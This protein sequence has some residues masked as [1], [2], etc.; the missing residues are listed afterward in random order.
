MIRPVNDSALAL[1]RFWFWHLLY[2]LGYL[3]LKYT[4]L[5]LLIPLQQ[6][7][8]FPYLATYTLITVINLSL[9]GW[10]GTRE[11]ARPCTPA[12]QLQR[13]AVWLM[14]LLFLL[15]PLRQYLLTHYA[16]KSG[17]DMM[18][19]WSHYLVVGIPLVLLPL[20]GW[21]AVFLLM[22]LNFFTL[23]QLENRQQL[24]KQ[25]RQARLKVLRYQ[26]NPHFMFNTLNALNSLIVSRKGLAAEDLI[27]QLSAFL[28]H[29]LKNQDD[30]WVPLR[31]ELQ[32]LEAYLAI[33]Q[34]R[35]G[36][37]LV[38]DWQ[39]SATKPMQLPPLLFQ[40][41]AEQAIL[42]TVAEQSGPI[43]L[44]IELTEPCEP[45][46]HTGML[47]FIIRSD[48]AGTETQLWS[49]SQV[50]ASLQQLQ[51]RL[52]LLFGPRASLTLLN[53]AFG[54]YARLNLPLEVLYAAHPAR[55]RGR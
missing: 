15:I 52:E 25:A 43:H 45:G 23:Q 27:Q 13:L 17:P 18:T 33:Q 46:E 6:E 12:Q 8:A 49:A 16:M 11:L 42:W 3:L 44:H 47:Q 32:A 26:L 34:V 54:F 4:H 31:E 5:S 38:L 10:L 24:L 28:R 30:Q 37:R 40:P 9:T 20:C 51:E 55:D 53:P 36:E 50:P 7:A 1:T 2:W 41:M 39:L 35:F 14:P 29:S 19:H 22:K 48:A 21:V